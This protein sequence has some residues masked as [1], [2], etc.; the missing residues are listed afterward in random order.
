MISFSNKLLNCFTI[1]FCICSISIHFVFYLQLHLCEPCVNIWFST[2]FHF[3]DKLPLESR[4]LSR[5]F[6]S[7]F[8][9]IKWVNIIIMKHRFITTEVS[10]IIYSTW[11]KYAYPFYQNRE[12]FHDQLNIQFHPNLRYLNR[13][14]IILFNKHWYNNILNETTQNIKNINTNDETMVFYLEE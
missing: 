8:V 14:L 10:I 7:C 1:R 5:S 2:I 13:K 12:W 9:Q 3:K 11:N 4:R 6:Y